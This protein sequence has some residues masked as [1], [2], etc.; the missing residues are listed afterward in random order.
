MLMKYRYDYAPY[1]DTI[2]TEV[3]NNLYVSILIFYFSFFGPKLMSW[4]GGC[5]LLKHIPRLSIPPHI[6]NTDSEKGAWQLC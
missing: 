6:G 2:A 5:L 1:N 4:F 3:F